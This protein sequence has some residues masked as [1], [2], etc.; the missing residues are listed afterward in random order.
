MLVAAIDIHD[1]ARLLR[2]P[3]SLLPRAGF[4]SPFSSCQTFGSSRLARPLVVRPL[5]ASAVRALIIRVEHFGGD[6]ARVGRLAIGI[7]R[8]AQ[9]EADLPWFL[10]SS[11]FCASAGVSSSVTTGDSARADP[12]LARSERCARWRAL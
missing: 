8:I 3:S 4:F 9:R 2:L 10:A 7:Q 5:L 11:S 6:R 1:R 12:A